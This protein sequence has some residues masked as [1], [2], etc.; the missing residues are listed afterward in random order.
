MA[1]NFPF[2]CNILKKGRN[3]RQQEFRQN[4]C[5]DYFHEKNL[6][7]F[8]FSEIGEIFC[9]RNS[10]LLTVICCPII[11]WVEVSHK[12]DISRAQSASDIFTDDWPTTSDILGNKSL[13]SKTISILTHMKGRKV[14]RIL[15]MFPAFRH[16]MKRNPAKN[17]VTWAF[18]S[19]S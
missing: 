10:F 11:H 6:A 16:Y 9:L 7:I 13:V 2:S 17:F 12:V 5:P 3:L 4:W 15:Q 8:V 14:K 1:E 18:T 19:N